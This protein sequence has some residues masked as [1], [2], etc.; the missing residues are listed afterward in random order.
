M[1]EVKK[2]YEEKGGSKKDNQEKEKIM[3]C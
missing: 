1:E 3:S 2:S